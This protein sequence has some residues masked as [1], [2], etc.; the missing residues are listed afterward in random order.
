[1][2][3]S[4]LDPPR[5][6]REGDVLAVVSQTGPTVSFFDAASDRHL[7]TLEVLAEPHELCFDPT[8]RLLWCATAYHSGY[9]HANTGRRTE[10]T[11]IDPDT[12]R[13][14]EVVDLAPEHGPHGLALDAARRRL[15]VS[16]EGSADRPGGVVVIDTET[17]RP[18]GRI[19]T[20]A[21]GPH[22]FA[23]DPAGRIGYATNKEAP[24]VSIV[25]L[26]RGVLTAKVE[27]PGSEGLA[28]SADGTHAFVAAP[29]AGSAIASS[30]SD[31]D[32]PDHDR[33]VTGIRV[34]D[35]RTAAVVDTLPTRDIVLPV[36]LTSTGK[37]LV[38]EV[39]MAPDPASGL[40]RQ[41]PGRLTVFAAD[42]R[43]RLGQLDVGLFPLTI[44]SSPDGRL[45]Y[46]SNLVSSTV[47]IV[48]LETFQGLGR[49]DIAKR[50]E[51]GAHGLAYIPRP[52]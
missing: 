25:D 6:S 50:G 28:V 26:E 46:V 35:A 23:I 36:H 3:Q 22:W 10:L 40:G 24:F 19:D 43:R 11:V 29:Y 45:A 52:S 41:T 48:D 12:R 49:L 15:Y 18:I 9:Y 1:M 34:V 33:P 14:V 16:V 37:L 20:D 44:T 17:R 30:G 13:I 4:P 21:P 32:A 7:G 27:V 47:D 42:T 38:G 2:Q 5:A 51:A 8:Q 39:R 31:A